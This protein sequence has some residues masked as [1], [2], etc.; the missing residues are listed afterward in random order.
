M[1][2]VT[3]AKL[4]TNLFLGGIGD[5][6]SVLPPLGRS[7]NLSMEFD[8]GVGLYVVAHDE[9]K[10]ARRLALIPASSVAY[11][12]YQEEEPSSKVVDLGNKKSK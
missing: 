4:H 12:I 7:L 9:V 2:K 11:V 1:H 5:L 10:H 3:Y 8:P 6:G